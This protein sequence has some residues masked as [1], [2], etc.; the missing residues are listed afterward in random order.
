MRHREKREVRVEEE[1]RVTRGCSHGQNKPRP[2]T[3]PA[4]VK[5]GRQH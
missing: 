4:V 1:N 2:N 3:R 5:V